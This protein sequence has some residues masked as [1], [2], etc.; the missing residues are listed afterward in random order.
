MAV[1]TDT[2]PPP[3]ETDVLVIGAGAGGSAA[4]WALA[5]HGVNVTLIDAG[6]AFSP[7][8]YGV[9]DD[10]WERRRFP[11]K[12]GSRGRYTFAPGQMLD[13]AWDELREVSPFFSGKT[14]RTTRRMYRYGHVRGVGGTTLHFT[15]WMHRLHPQAF[16][17]RTLFGV[18]A[19]WPLTYQ[20]LEPYYE[21]AEAV[22]GVAGPETVANRPRRSPFPTP[23][24]PMNRLSQT[25]RTGAR[26]LGYSWTENPISSPSRPYGG[27]PACNYCGCCHWGCPI[28]DKGSADVTFLPAAVETGKCTI[29]PRRTLVELERGLGDEIVAAIVVGEDGER[30]RIAANH[31]VLAAGAIETPRLLLAMNGLGNESGQVGRNFM[32]SI[33]AYMVGLHPDPVG[34]H[35][36]YPEDSVT[37]DLNAPDAIP[38]S[39]GGALILPWVASSRLLGPAEYATQLI[40]GFGT[41]HKKKL[42]EAFGHA[43]GTMAICENL[44]NDDSYVTLDA[45][46]TDDHGLPLAQINSFLPDR[47]L[48]RFSYARSVAKDILLASGVP[49]IL[50][51]NSSYERFS[52]SH[53]FGTCRMGHS[54]DTTVVAAN[55]RSHR[56]RNLWISDASV[57]PTSGSGEGPTL[58]IHAL[59]IRT[60]DA[61]TN[62][63][64]TLSR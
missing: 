20:E 36:G 44:P 1:A 42:R 49:E 8:E 59:A 39:I 27:R 46:Q 62:K 21:I 37:W 43:V 4:A 3:S 55:G 61:I 17:M 34:S 11:R 7:T 33:L 32:E 26:K 56:W 16:E 45:Q 63:V 6:P 47:E 25:L 28:S 64:T 31:F 12:P 60:A 24:H 38:G 22:V 52:S 23:A 48:T 40:D 54:E 29:H 10:D 9:A 2:G 14:A 30:H 58:T 18:A 57:F 5:R 51:A 13:P 15:G 19:D 41:D 50:L 53:V 35:R